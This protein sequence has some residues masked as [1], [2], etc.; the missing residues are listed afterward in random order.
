[1]RVL[2]TGGAGFIGSNLVDALHGRG[3][4]PGV[5]D[6]LSTGRAENLRGDVWM[7]RIDILDATMPAA[8]AEFRPEAVVHLA[9]QVDVAASVSDPN[10]DWAVNVDGTQAVAAAAAACGA[11]LMLSASSAAVYGEPEIVPLPETAAKRPDSPYGR[12]KLAAEGALA[13]ELRAAAVDF[14]AMRFANVYG[15]RQ[16]WMGEG[17]VV[18]IFSHRMACA[19]APV[20]YGTGEQTRDFIYVSDVVDAIL[21]MLGSAAPLAG[22]GPDG[23]AYNVSTGLRTSVTELIEVIRPLAGYGGVV[24][25]ASPRS[26]DIEHSA[27]DPAK[28]AG[29]TGWRAEVPLAKGLATTMAWF[30]ERR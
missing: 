22:E 16:S 30:A 24:E 27:L 23:P 8:V 29:V 12:S 10:R 11:R 20:V 19:T 4:V 9:A 25:H 1:M 26:G 18:A 6:D 17:G 14:A 2:V 13:E 7:R 3:H 5:I 15:P 21:A 28:L